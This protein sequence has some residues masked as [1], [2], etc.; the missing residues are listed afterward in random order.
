M[1]ERDYQAKLIKKLKSLYPGCMI[2]KNDSGY[3]QG[4]PDLTI[5]YKDKWA[6]LE[7]KAKTPK[8]ANAFEPNQ[9]WFLEKMGEMSFAA[10]VYPENEEDVLN[11]IQQT[12]TSGRSSRLSVS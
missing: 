11:G 2:L 10:C 7:V 5:L 6:A 12:F 4:I 8:S 3:M 9:E 1:R